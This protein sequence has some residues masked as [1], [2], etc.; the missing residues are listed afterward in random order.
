[1]TRKELIEDILDEKIKNHLFNIVNDINVSTYKY[2]DADD[3]KKY[4]EIIEHLKA[5]HEILDTKNNFSIKLSGLKK[6]E[7]VGLPE[8]LNEGDKIES[9]YVLTDINTFGL[10]VYNFEDKTFRID[11]GYGGEIWNANSIVAW[12]YWVND[13]LEVE[14]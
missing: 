7:E 12:C 10:A 4:Q 13:E 11:N 1:M 6:V 3:K 14:A 5:C 9:I 8:P 2:F